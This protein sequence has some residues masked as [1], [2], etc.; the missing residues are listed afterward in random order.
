[1]TPAALEFARP[2]LSSAGIHLPPVGLANDRREKPGHRYR[3]L[4]RQLFDF[5]LAV[6]GH[7]LADEN[8][9]SVQLRRKHSVAQIRGI[10]GVLLPQR[11]PPY[12]RR[13]CPGC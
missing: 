7:Q 12:P 3:I 2:F 10:S 5:D 1:M 11:A 9:I 4:T 13:I 8:R 6:L